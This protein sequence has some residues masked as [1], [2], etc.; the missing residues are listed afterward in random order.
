MRLVCVLI[1]PFLWSRMLMN[2][3]PRCGHADDK[4]KTQDRKGLVS[5]PGCVGLEPS[6]HLECPPWT[7]LCERKKLLPA[8]YIWGLLVRAA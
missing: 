4:V 2:L 6:A 3:Q 5:E 1:S 7:V 8:L